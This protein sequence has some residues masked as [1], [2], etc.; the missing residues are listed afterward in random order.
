ML[1]QQ[2][3]LFVAVTEAG[4]F[5]TAARALNLSQPA[6]GA[7]AKNLEASLGVRLLE[8]HSRGIAL[9]PAGR[10]FLVEA[11][12]VLAAV[13]RARAAVA[14]FAGRTEMP[15]VLGFTPTSGRTLVPDLLTEAAQRL[16]ELRLQLRAGLSDDHRRG[17]LAASDLD[18]AFCYDP[19]P[20]EAL[21]IH[22][23][24]EEDLFLVGAPGLVDRALGPIPLAEVA[25]LPLMLEQ[26]PHG[27]RRIIEEAARSIGA[28]LDVGLDVEPAEVKRAL[29]MRR[30]HCTLVPYGLFM[31]EI[32]AGLMGA[33]RVVAPPIHR[34]LALAMRRTL[35]A[36]VVQ[37][38]LALVRPIARRKI[39]EGAC[40]WRAPPAGGG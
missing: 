23:L 28:R 25:R 30:G 13:E 2:I 40:G 9:T 29:I 7:Q 33:R 19:E 31:E 21:L 5:T 17:L 18:A 20:H 24:Y 11:K 26:R 4:S 38:L 37:G 10:A 22:P 3:R 36:V 27:A 8:R 34:T 39:E 32:A 1:F 12:A 15:V 16:P 6:L 35:P 14:P